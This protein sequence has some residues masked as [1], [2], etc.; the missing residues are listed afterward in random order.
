M[1]ITAKSP[2]DSS[3][4]FSRRYF[5]W[6]K[7]FLDDDDEEEILT[8]SS[9]SHKCKEAKEAEELRIPVPSQVSLV[10][11]PKKKLQLWQFPSFGQ[12]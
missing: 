10:P 3:F 9:S 7:K 1:K 5:N 4:S 8:F 6:K 11:A 12:L 2:H